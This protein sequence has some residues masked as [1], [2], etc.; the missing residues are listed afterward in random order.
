[1]KIT[2][3][4]ANGKELYFDTGASVGELEQAVANRATLKCE[5]YTGQTV[6]LNLSMVA[7]VMYFEEEQR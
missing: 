1:M 2:A 4:L 3:I 6:L 7:A 5:K